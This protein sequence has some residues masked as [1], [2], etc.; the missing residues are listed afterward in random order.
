M[1]KET[2]LNASLLLIS[3]IIFFWYKWYT[4]KHYGLKGS[5]SAS[6]D[7]LKKEGKQFYTYFFVVIGLCFPLAWIAQTWLTTIAVGLMSCIGIITGYN[8]RL[9]NYKFQHVLHVILAFIPIAI[10]MA[11]IIIEINVMYA[12]LIGTFV[13]LSIWL[14]VKKTPDYVRKIEDLAYYCICMCLILERIILL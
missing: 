5:I 9:K 1:I 14:V 4:K 11:G 7:D 12:Y 6:A 13:I 8:D 10:F 2:L 3:L